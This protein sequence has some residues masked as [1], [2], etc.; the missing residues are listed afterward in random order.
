MKLLLFSLG[1]LD[2]HFGSL[3]GR[4]LADFD[5]NIKDRATGREFLILRFFKRNSYDCLQFLE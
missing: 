3:F 4:F 5:K 1:Q 2:S